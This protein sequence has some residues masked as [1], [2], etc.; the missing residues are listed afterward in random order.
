MVGLSEGEKHFIRGGIAQDIRT[1]GRR[2]LQFRA[3]SVE[4]GVIPQVPGFLLALFIV[5]RMLFFSAMVCVFTVFW[6]W[7]LL[8]ANG[9]ARVRLGGTE[10][11]AS[12]KVHDS[13]SNKG[14]FFWHCI[15]SVFFCKKSLLAVK[16]VSINSYARIRKVSINPAYHHPPMLQN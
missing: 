15:S 1:D 10:V 4:T 16:F 8:Q 5:P 7:W 3:L 13:C 2:R 6:D 12:V 11:I 14:A 9:S